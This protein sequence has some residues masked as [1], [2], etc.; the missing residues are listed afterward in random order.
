M[1]DGDASS[2]KEVVKSN[3][4]SEFDIVPGRVECVGHVQNRL[5]TRLLK[6]VMEYK[7]AATPLSG[8]GKLTEK[9]INSSQ[10]F[11][12]IAI[13]Q[14]IGNL[15]EMKKAVGAILWHCTDMKDIEILL[16]RRIQ[17]V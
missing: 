14:N 4:Y 15:S 6:I 17:L 9:I 10:N 1:G 16:K 5:G 13:R 3:P 11:Y 12:V 2:L 8:K 7:G